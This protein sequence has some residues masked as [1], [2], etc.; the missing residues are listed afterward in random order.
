M[1]LS[2]NTMLVTG[3]GSGIGQALAWQFQQRGNVVI[4]A[5]RTA[6]SLAETVAGRDAMH[7]LP[8][9]V[10]DEASVATAA[11]VLARD[12]PQL[13]MLVHAAGIMTRQELGSGGT[14]DTARQVIDINLIGTMRVVEAL[15]PQLA[16]QPDAAI[17]T[18]SSG[19]AFA[20]LPSTPAYSAS[21]AAVHS[22]TMSLRHRLKGSVQVIEVAPPA[23]QTGLTPGQ[24]SRAGYMPLDDY[25]AETMPNFEREPGAEENLVG[26]V[27]PLRHAERDGRMEQV[28]DMLGSL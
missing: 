15:I 18:V 2:G 11:E 19:L 9:D 17:C 25:I 5:G 13:N 7:M 6:A 3:G 28:L 24:A 22:Y 23:V 16:G 4:V 14:I 20:P 27:L 8:L 12:F 10:A 26:N 21:K 1:K